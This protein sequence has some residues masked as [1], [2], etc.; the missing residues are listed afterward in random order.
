MNNKEV[1]FK[2]NFKQLSWLSY[3]SLLFWAL[4]S[5]FTPEQYKILSKISNFILIPC[6]LI[7]LFHLLQSFAGRGKLYYKPNMLKNVGYV[8]FCCVLVASES[9]TQLILMIRIFIV[10]LILFFYLQYRN[11]LLINLKIKSINLRLDLSELFY[12]LFFSFILINLLLYGSLSIDFYFPSIMDKNYTGILIYFFLMLSFHRK[13]IVG[14]FICFFYILF[15]TQSRSLYGM[16]AIY[17]FIKIFRTRIYNIL[18]KVHFKNTFKQFLLLFIGIVCLSSFWI[19]FVAVNPL[20]QYREGLNDGSN[21][22]RFAANIY[23]EHQMLNNPQYF[24]KGLGDDIKEVF[25]IADED[26][27]LHTQ[28]MGIRLVQPHN[29]FLNMMLKIGIFEAILYFWLLSIILDKIWSKNNME[30]YLPYLINACFMHSLLNGAYL[31]IWSFILISTLDYAGEVKSCNYKIKMP[32][33][34]F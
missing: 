6:I 18:Q 12:W 21:K 1:L 26:T 16:I 28:F 14:I 30:Y 7:F 11:N 17:F 22:M 3:V 34:I 25:G 27:T 23:A 13:N 19:Q 9:Y 15:M 31:V 4:I 33:S 5:L 32:F 2:F 10:L 20:S 24:Y 29:C 8:V